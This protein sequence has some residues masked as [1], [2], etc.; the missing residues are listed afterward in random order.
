MRY[1]RWVG[2]LVVLA[3][4]SAGPGEA[5]AQARKKA[6]G[7]APPGI[8]VAAAPGVLVGHTAPIE[9]LV[10]SRDGSTLASGGYDKTVRLWDAA[11]GKQRA[12]LQASKLVSGLAFSPDGSLIASS[13]GIVW[14]TATGR[15]KATGCGGA[16]GMAFLPD[17]K[18]I[19][20]Y[21]SGGKIA[22]VDIE[23]AKVTKE[24][25]A[26]PAP[27]CI[28]V[29]VDGKMVVTATNH[30]AEKGKK[31]YSV[32]LL[33]LATGKY[34]P[35][36]PGVD[37]DSA[38]I[39]FS[40]DGR[41]VAA[42]GL[43]D[44]GEKMLEHP[45]PEGALKVWDVGTGRLIGAIPY[46]LKPMRPWS[47]ALAFSADGSIIAVDRGG[48]I[49]LW[50]VSPFEL[51]ATLGD[52]PA[53]EWGYD[54][55]AFSPDGRTLA[56]AESDTRKSDN[57][58][59]IRLFVVPTGPARRTPP[60]TAAP[61]VVGEVT[62]FKGHGAGVLGVAFSRDGRFVL[63]G[64]DD[65]FAM[66]WEANTGR[67]VMKFE[68]HE[69]S[70]NGVAMSRDGKK[71]LT[72]SDDKTARLWDVTTGKELLKLEGHEGGISQVAI[73]FDASRAATAGSDKMARLWNLTTGK[74]IQTFAG[75]SDKLIGVAI[76]PDGKSLLTGSW[77]KTA[78]LWD[79]ATGKEIR[80][81]T[82]HT[83]KA[84][85]VTFSADG[86]R[87]LTAS[88]DHTLR[89]WDVASGAEL[90]RVDAGADVG[91]AVA[92]SP[93]GRRALTV[94]EADVTLWDIQA[95]TLPTRLKGHSGQ[96][97]G[98]AFSADG[99]FAVSGSVDGTARVWRL[100]RAAATPPR[101]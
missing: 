81:F 83:D 99:R 97:R 9:V 25:E 68:G 49:E 46:G 35:S 67:S 5:I 8:V 40:P 41:R 73:N 62:V 89:L 48:Q 11:T 54:A 59:R 98:L 32:T 50:S 90:A 82:G 34:R 85:A 14:E 37:F 53:F 43:H 7:N 23:T 6:R 4:A 57:D 60:R 88:T 65:K 26:G 12:V 70:V 42:T 74:E 44:S 75:H 52:L 47:H 87:V 100:P 45:I 86:R 101:R 10:F 22:L 36:L 84:G 27:S 24:S 96:I 20:T 17:G 16:Q 66:L 39:A 72:G 71:A 51:V 91:W 95:R 94:D 18:T 33:D 15:E 76:S 58:T 64:A 29:T 69:A 77:D 92:I 2:S 30:A 79:L 38:D 78:R 13:D 61:E 19:V 28:A 1:H 21:E 93:D 55:L 3:L 31:V 80:T 63:S 56:A